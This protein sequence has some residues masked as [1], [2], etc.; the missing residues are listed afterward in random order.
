MVDFEEV[1]ISNPERSTSENA[2]H[3]RAA[4]FSVFGYPVFFG[5]VVVAGCFCMSI[6]SGAFFYARGIFLP[7]MADEFGGSRLDVTL[8]FTIAQAVGAFA[9]PVIGHLLDK[10]HPRRILLGGAVMVTMG[11]VATAYASTYLMLYAI[12]GLLF[13][14]GWRAI[15][16]F[17]TSRVLVQWFRRKRGLALSLDVA[18][19]SFAGVFVPVIAV[20]LMAT[21]GWRVGFASF[22]VLT[23]GLVVPLV[24][25]VIHRAPEDLGLYPDGD[26]EPLQAETGGET[27][28]EA[29]RGEERLWTTR[30]LFRIPAFWMLIVL[31]SAMFCVWQGVNMHLFGHF[32]NG[33]FTAEQAGV[34]LSLMGLFIL[35]GKPILGWFA[36]WATPKAAIAVALICQLVGVFL[37]WFG[38]TYLFAV[39]GVVT[40]GFGFSSVTPLQSMATAAVFGTAAYGKANGLMQPFMLPVALIASPLAAWIYDT[41]GSYTNAFLQFLIILVVALPILVLIKLRAPP[42]LNRTK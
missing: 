19:A 18:G 21:Y 29:G 30:E 7:Q 4:D 8:A 38:D 33:R 9:A 41:T 32:T 5:W 37:F 36:D 39:L 26:K 1:A 28:G 13:G 35:S 23:I 10:H 12:F 31:F 27:E 40:Y 3:K 6:V 20:W 11:Y 2:K 15:S 22:G 17:A 14:A 16:S 24:M 34:L 42:D 25:F